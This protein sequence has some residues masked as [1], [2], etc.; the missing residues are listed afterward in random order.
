MRSKLA[1]RNSIVNLMNQLICIVLAMVVRRYL[2][3]YLGVEI[4]GVNATIVE[5]INMLALSELGIQ[6]SISYRLYK[7]IA[8]GDEDKI[9]EIFTLF[10]KAYRI[11]GT[12]ILIGGI[13]AIPFIHLIVNTTI[14]MKIVYL[15]YIIQLTA[16]AASYYVNY[17]RTLLGAYQNQ[18]FCTAVD[19]VFNIVIY[20][21]KFIVIIYTRSYIL[22]LLLQFVQLFGSNYIISHHCKKKY[23]LVL[24]K[25]ET[26]KEEK[27]NLI[28][29]LK[30]I[31]LGN[32]SGYV[33]RSTDSMVISA[34]C[35]SLLV[36]LLSNYKTITQ[37][38]RQLINIVNSSLNPTW[39][40]FLSEDKNKGRIKEMFDMFVFL[41]FVICSI[42]LIPIICL[43]DEFVIMWIGKDYL[44]SARLLW[45]IILD[46]YMN[47]VH[48]PNCMI[49][50]GYGMFKE[51]KWIS[52]AAA[53]V[54][55]VS[56]IILVQFLGIEGVLIGTLLA[57]CIYW[58]GRSYVVNKKCFENSKSI[59]GKYW[60]M[61]A[62]YI[63]AFVVIAVFAKFVVTKLVIGNAIVQFICRGFL[64]E[65]I[66][67][68]A[69]LICFGSS[70]NMK[71]AYEVILKPYLSKLI[72]K[73]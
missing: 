71:K 12:I 39:G 16:T 14:D 24:K 62:I 53:I 40:N 67:A 9:G 3:H 48:E 25:Y 68:A 34:F 11:V 13:I 18:Y 63:I 60:L 65:S 45:L 73:G 69:I 17:Y 31:V 2:I 33:Y 58:I 57:L 61:N 47:T 56:S 44:I 49:M 10:K 29:D 64:A 70:K 72:R 41:Q 52:A 4:L 15:V 55:L 30:E 37:S 50:R 22:Y 66:I 38:I 35:G 27:T 19:I 1:V 54:N 32:I 20:A 36:G 7:P 5:V 59:Y 28:A 26:S 8:D 42:M 43:A 46:I 6:Y 23:P 21:L 51:D